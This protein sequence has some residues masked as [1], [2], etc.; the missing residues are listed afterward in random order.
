MA[1]RRNIESA[2]ARATLTELQLRKKIPGM[3]P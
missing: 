2:R 3:L 1:E